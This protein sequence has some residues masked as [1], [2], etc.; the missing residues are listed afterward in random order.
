V[1]KLL[2]DHLTPRKGAFPFFF[3]IEEFADKTI[4]RKY[5]RRPPA[6]VDAVIGVASGRFVTSRVT[7]PRDY[8][9]ASSSGSRGVFRSFVLYEGPVYR[10]HEHLRFSGERTYFM[11]RWDG[12]TRELSAEEVVAC[13]EK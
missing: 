7:A 9:R 13:L 4:L 5:R 12:V 11:R 1:F 2:P 6:S 10:V 8:S 3:E